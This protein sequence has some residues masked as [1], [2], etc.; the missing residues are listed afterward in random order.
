MNVKDK[1]VLITGSTRGIGNAIAREF[2]LE[3]AK[4]VICGSKIENA[5]KSAKVLI[6]ELNVPEDNV[7]P[8]GINMKDSEDIKRVVDE[9][10]SKWEKVD[11]L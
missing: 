4:V 11:V 3:G 7:L 5:I 9:V 1:I 2:L 10:I 8:V 6:E